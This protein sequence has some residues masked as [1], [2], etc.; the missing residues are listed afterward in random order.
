MQDTGPVHVVQG[1]GQPGAQPGHGLGPGQRRQFGAGSGFGGADL[2]FVVEDFVDRGQQECPG[3]IGRRG[4]ADFAEYG[5][6]GPAGDVLHVQE[7]KPWCGQDVPIEDPHDVVV[8]ELGERLRFGAGIGGDLH[9]D[10]PLHGALPGQEDLGEGAAA[11]QGEQIE[12]V[13]PGTGLDMVDGCRFFA[14]CASEQRAAVLAGR[15]EF[16][17]LRGLLRVLGRVF[18]GVDRFSRGATLVVFLVDE[19]RG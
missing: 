6:Q 9:R 14:G 12:I 15:Q 19:I 8:V 13:D 1:P 18:V 11:E 7:S 3:A 5:Q 4:V 16:G 10:Q 2:A 17:Q